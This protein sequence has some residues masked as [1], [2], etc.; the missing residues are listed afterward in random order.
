MLYPS[1]K[2]ILKDPN[3]P[4]S[5]LLIERNVHGDL[6][7]EPAGGKVE[8]DFTNKSAE[9]LEACALREIREELGYSIAID[10]YIGSYYF[11]WTI[12][13]TKCSVCAVFTGLITNRDAI[14]IS[15]A[16]SYELPMRPL[17]VTREDILKN[18]VTVDPCRKGLRELLLQSF[19]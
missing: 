18:R 10:R 6:S 4:G 13:P 16:D 19:S 5:I 12:D 11:F 1:A 7:V 14:F 3:R 17:W 2:V 15:N 9:N 8:V